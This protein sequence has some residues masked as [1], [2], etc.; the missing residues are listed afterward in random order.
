VRFQLTFAG[1]RA[2]FEGSSLAL[3]KEKKIMFLRDYAMTA[4]RYE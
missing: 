4:Q 1:N 3:L 2:G